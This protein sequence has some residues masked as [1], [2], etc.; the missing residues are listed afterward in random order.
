MGIRG[1]IRHVRPFAHSAS[2]RDQ[3]V[4]IDGPA[5]AHH[6]YHLCLGARGT[7]NNALEAA[8][9]YGELVT[10]AIAWLEDLKANRVSM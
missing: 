3:E 8:P 1:L 6:V 9:S 2:L 4:V 10:A 5:F 7:A